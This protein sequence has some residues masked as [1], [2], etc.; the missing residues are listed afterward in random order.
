MKTISEIS[1]L[2]RVDFEGIL[3]ILDYSHDEHYIYVVLEYADGGDIQR[4]VD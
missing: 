3:S 4:S 1:H 2:Q